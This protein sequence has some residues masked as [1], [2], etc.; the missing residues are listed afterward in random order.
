MMNT[1]APTLT[2][3]QSHRCQTLVTTS[4]VYAY[5]EIKEIRELTYNV[6]LI[7]LAWIIV[8]PEFIQAS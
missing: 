8:V 4:I 3:W 1:G 6:R 7:G 2:H 5:E